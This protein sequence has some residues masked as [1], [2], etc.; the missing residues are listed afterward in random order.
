MFCLRFLKFVDST[1]NNKKEKRN[2]LIG[3]NNLK[4]KILAVDDNIVNIK[5]LTQYLVKQ[6]YNVITAE[7]GEEAIEKFT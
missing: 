5:V 1:L 4:V 7:S 3:M 2:N 6:E